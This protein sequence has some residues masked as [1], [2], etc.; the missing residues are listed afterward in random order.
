MAYRNLDRFMK[1]TACDVSKGS[2]SV[3]NDAEPE[4]TSNGMTETPATML[5]GS[6]YFSRPDAASL[7][8]KVYRVTEY[9]FRWKCRNSDF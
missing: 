1:P 2:E 9:K 8:F 5:K 6:K 7:S 4:G 3:G